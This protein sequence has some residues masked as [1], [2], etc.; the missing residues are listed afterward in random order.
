MIAL[1]VFYLHTVAITAGFTKRWQEEGLG[2]GLLAVFFMALIFFVGWSIT[3]FVMKLLID[4]Q[5]FGTWLDRDALSLLLLTVA[6]SVFYFIFLRNWNP[7]R[8]IAHV[9]HEPDPR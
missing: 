8:E 2:E 5:G 1:V 7:S 9:N 6:E 3:S 4:Q